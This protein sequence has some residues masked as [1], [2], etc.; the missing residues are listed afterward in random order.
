MLRVDLEGKKAHATGTR[1]VCIRDGIGRLEF[2]YIFKN[3]LK[4]KTGLLA[5]ANTNFQFLLTVTCRRCFKLNS[6]EPQCLEFAT[7][8]GPGEII[9]SVLWSNSQSS[10]ANTK[11][12][13]VS[14]IENN[15]S[16]GLLWSF[17]AAEYQNIGLSSGFPC[18]CFTLW[19][20]CPH[21]KGNSLTLLPAD[22][23]LCG[24]CSLKREVDQSLICGEYNKK[25]H[26]T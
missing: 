18:G 7:S 5:F 21:R 25:K 11:L 19:V 17:G 4:K 2:R 26:P 15:E 10:D 1:S 3:I 8:P 12:K 24:S 9:L 20:M 16:K 23:L 6:F 13:L 22:L 14:G